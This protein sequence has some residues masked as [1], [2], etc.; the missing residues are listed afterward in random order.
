MARARTSAATKVHGDRRDDLIESALAVLRRDGPAALTMRNVADEAGVTATALYRHYADKEA[1]LADIVRAAYRVFR[2]SLLVEVPSGNAEVWLR[3][4]HD[5]FLT[6]ALEHPN[7]YR[8]LFLERQGIGIDHYP[9][10]FQQG[11]SAGVRHLREVVADCMRAGVLAGEP[12]KNATD[13]ALT[14]Y[15]HMHGLIALYLGGRFPDV[16]VFQRFY[17]QSLDALLDG[18]RPRGTQDPTAR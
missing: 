16:Q 10:D 6:F 5:R 2:Q 1:L 3:L 7:Y 18:L 11:K 12:S 14:V 4:A 8:L 9:A 17:L 13:V 15:A